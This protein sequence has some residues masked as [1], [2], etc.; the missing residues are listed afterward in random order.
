[1]TP[2]LRTAVSAIAFIAIAGCSRTEVHDR[3]TVS[4]TAPGAF[5][6][7]RSFDKT[8]AAAQA[9]LTALGCTY[10]PVVTNADEATI[11]V[12]ERPYDHARFWIYQ[13]DI[14][15][16]SDAI[17]DGAERRPYRWRVQD[18]RYP[19]GVAYAKSD[20]DAADYLPKMP[21]PEDCESFA[22]PFA[23]NSVMVAGLT[24]HITRAGDQSSKIRIDAQAPRAPYHQITYA[25]G[26]WRIFHGSADTAKIDAWQ[27]VQPAGSWLR[28]TFV[29]PIQDLASTH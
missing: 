9:H 24:I 3:I 10:K 6:V 21:S 29:Q 25:K 8:V 26:V 7:D 20:S 19:D 1:M 18:L 4:Y 5:T 28:S 16:V 11:E 22:L 23:E 17:Q 27:T 13:R 12:A 15:I 14:T 2:T